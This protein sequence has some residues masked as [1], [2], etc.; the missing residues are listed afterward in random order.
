MAAACVS[1]SERERIGRRNGARCITQHV[2]REL[3]SVFSPMNAICTLGVCDGKE[4]REDSI[5]EL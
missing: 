2:E 3:D 5:S 4:G 1:K